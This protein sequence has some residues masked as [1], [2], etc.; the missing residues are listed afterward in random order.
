MNECMLDNRH[1]GQRDGLP[2]RGSGLQLRFLS[3]YDASAGWG[4]G[5]RVSRRGPPIAG[6]GSNSRGDGLFLTNQGS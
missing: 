2:Q 1:H 6:G 4:P 3:R 5:S